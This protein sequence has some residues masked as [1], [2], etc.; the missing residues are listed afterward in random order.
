VEGKAMTEESITE[1]KEMVEPVLSENGIDLVALKVHRSRRNIVVDVLADRPQGGIT[2]EDCA[3]LNRKII[4]VLEAKQFF[5]QD[6]SLSVASPG[7]DWPMKSRKD[8]LRALNRPVRVHLEAAPGQP[9][10]CNGTVQ[11]V[12]DEQVVLL[13]KKGAQSIALKDIRKAVQIIM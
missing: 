2:I 8:F 13:T 10:E 5:G 6:F 4:D 12:D 1:L 7:L 3:R 9:A 11:S